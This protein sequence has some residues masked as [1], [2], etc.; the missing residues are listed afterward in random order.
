MNAIGHCTSWTLLIARFNC[1]SQRWL[2]IHLSTH[3]RSDHSRSRSYLLSRPHLK[4]R[5]P[6]VGPRPPGWKTL[7]GR[8]SISANKFPSAKC[9]DP[10][11]SIKKKKRKKHLIKRPWTC[12]YL[13]SRL[14]TALLSV[15]NFHRPAHVRLRLVRDWGWSLPKSRIKSTP[16]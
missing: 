13:H 4:Y 10:F 12:T 14:Q 16:F 8:I 15:Y 11:R 1:Q 5:R 2:N 7:M 3:S 6:H 9:I